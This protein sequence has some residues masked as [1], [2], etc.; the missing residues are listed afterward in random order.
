MARE[1]NKLVNMR[2]SDLDEWL[3]TSRSMDSGFPKDDGSGETVGHE[4]Y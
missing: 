2:A 1:F 3:Q 4:R